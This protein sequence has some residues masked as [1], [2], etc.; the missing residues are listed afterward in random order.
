MLFQVGLF[1]QTIPN[2]GENIDYLSTFGSDAE[3]QWGDNDHIQIVFF[4]IPR[5]YQKPV[6]IRVFDP[7]CGGQHDLLT[8]APWDTRTNF[9]IYGGAQAHSEKDAQRHEPGPN[10][11]SGNLLLSLEFSSTTGDD[12]W[13]TLGPFNPAEGEF[14]REL[15]GYIFK[16]IVNGVSGNDG[17]A[18]KLSL[19]TSKDANIPVPGGNAF[20]YN[21]TFRLKVAKDAVAHIYPFIDDKVVSFKQY[22]FDFDNEGEIKLYSVTKNGHILAMSGENELSFSEHQVDPKE[23]GKSMDIQIT[24]SENRVNDMTFYILNQ[25][26]EAIPFFAIPIGGVP[27]YSFNIDVKYDYV[28]QKRSY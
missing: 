25:Y 26:N 13:Y 22:N 17:N 2:S 10:Y 8:E 19:S 11:R 3:G 20:T 4:L 14:S 27:K 28:N 24:K 23:R 7:D 12:E 1:A 15:G 21:Y 6:Y 16:V 5:D 18:Y 9:S